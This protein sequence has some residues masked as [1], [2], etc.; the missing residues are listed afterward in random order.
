MIALTTTITRSTSTTLTT[1]TSTT[2]TSTSTTSTTTTSTSTTSTST[3]ST[4]ISSVTTLTF[5]ASLKKKENFLLRKRREY[6]SLPPAFKATTQH[7][8]DSSE[9]NHVIKDTDI[10]KHNPGGDC[11]SCYFKIEE[12][13]VSSLN[14]FDCMD[15]SI[16]IVYKFLNF[17]VKTEEKLGYLAYSNRTLHSYISD[18]AEGKQ[19]CARI[20][21]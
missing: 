12:F 15:R 17:K 18:K 19:E 3:T 9:K 16:Q 2:T 10:I 6:T 1:T 20:K 13:Y 5:T 4:L 11:V 7:F 21:K 8:F 14:T